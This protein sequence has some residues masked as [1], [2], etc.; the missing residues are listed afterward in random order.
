M[1]ARLESRDARSV[2]RR[3]MLS[4]RRPKSKRIPCAASKRHWARCICRLA[5]GAALMMMMAPAP[6]ASKS[7]KRRG[8]S[9]ASMTIIY[10]VAQ[11]ER[12]YVPRRPAA[13]GPQSRGPKS[14]LICF[15][16]CGWRKSLN[17]W[18][19]FN[20]SLTTAATTFQTRMNF[21]FYTATGGAAR[22]RPLVL[23]RR[24]TF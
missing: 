24:D 22:L 17:E 10:V 11:S 5:R 8:R 2:G 12:A 20:S 3:E 23:A 6:T 21:D 4:I 19:N 18:P 16:R 14:E 1:G 7:R 9:N 15:H 13:D